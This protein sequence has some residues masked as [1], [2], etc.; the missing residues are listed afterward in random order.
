MTST[1]MD[2][3]EN[4]EA[5]ERKYAESNGFGMPLDSKT[6]TR[7]LRA[8]NNDLEQAMTMLDATLVWREEFDVVNLHNW[9]S[10]MKV[11]NETGKAYVRG[12]DKQNRPIVWMKP[13]FENTYNHDGN[14]KHLVYNL[15]RAV[16]CGEA[17]G[18]EDGKICLVIDFEGYSIMNAPPMKTSM[19]TLSI[20]QNHYPERLAKA[21][22]VRPPW[23]FHSFFTLISPFIDPV[24]K[25]K[26]VMLSSKKHATLVENI[27]DC[28]LES[29]VGGQDCRPFDSSV[30]LG[31]QDLSVCYWDQLEA[32]ASIAEK[33]C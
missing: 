21:Y 1:E 6:F 2:L 3:T 11:E 33:T 9:A 12:K 28:Y 29:T 27:E 17:N 5:M 18:Y 30:Y 24:T 26:I 31:T 16:A 8:R 20:L 23:I 32:C 10:V 7:Y 13:K 15:E 14:I 4:L 25:E 22:L 19:E